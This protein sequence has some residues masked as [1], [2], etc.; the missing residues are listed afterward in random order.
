MSDTEQYEQEY[1][2]W[3]K[4]EP[5]ATRSPAQGFWDSLPPKVKKA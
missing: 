1:L 4:P 2:N 3:Y 5:T